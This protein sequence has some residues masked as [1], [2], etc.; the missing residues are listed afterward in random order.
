MN[1][2]SYLN[3]ES[4]RAQCDAAIKNLEEDNR[5]NGLITQKIMEFIAEPTLAGKSFEALRRQCCRR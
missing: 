3:P 2:S 1:G 4:I 5:V